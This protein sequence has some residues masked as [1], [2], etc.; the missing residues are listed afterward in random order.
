MTLATPR[1][2]DCLG[3]RLT[4]TQTHAV[5]ILNMTPD[6]F[7]DGGRLASVEE[8][9]F[10]ALAMV[11]AGATVID[12][13]GESTRPRGR[14]YGPGAASVDAA[15]EIARVV[16]VVRALSGLTPAVL[17]VDTTKAAVAAA[18]LEAGAHMVNDVSGM[19]MD[20]AMRSVVAS[21]GCAVVLMHMRGTP[22]TTAALGRFDDVVAE[23]RRE[24]ADVVDEAV[25]AGVREDRIVV[26]PGIGFGKSASQN[27]TLLHHLDALRVG[28]LPLY[29]GPS[30]KSFIG[31][32]LG[33]AP[34]EAREWG[35]AAAV[36]AA[37]LSGVEFV[38]VHD[39][40]AM[41]D[42]IRVAEA[43]RTEALPPC[44]T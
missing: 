31:A 27:L 11:D 24:L 34:P 40:R 18:A 35:T 9:V 15:E 33:G 37:V 43:I 5:A 12:I 17:S 21:A 29:V 32:A 6:S 7:S 41:M 20:P 1:E 8:A 44:R 42:V 25:A 30:R 28:S 38:R 23:V 4:L 26:D 3:V 36:T 2:L 13:G 16:P 19:R 14:A 10:H 39:V 22:Q